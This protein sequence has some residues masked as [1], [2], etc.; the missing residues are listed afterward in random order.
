MNDA[1][2]AGKRPQD[3]AKPTTAD[4][5]APAFEAAAPPVA[6]RRPT[7]RVYHARALDDDYAWLAAENWRDVLRDPAALP[8]DVEA[9]LRAENTYCDKVLAPLK[10]L[11]KSLVAEM[12]GRIK[13]DD[14]EVPTPDGPFVYYERYREGGE[15]PL[16]CRAPRDGGAEEILLDGETLAEGK[17]F[18]DIAAFEHARD[19]AQLAWS[20]DEN[21]GELY[22]IRTRALADGADRADV[23]ADTDGTVVWSADAGSFYYVRIDDN[24]RTAQVFRHD[25][26][27][28][29]ADDSL[30]FEERDPAWFVSLGESQ[31]GRFA[32]V[33]VHGHDATE[34]WLVDLREK[35]PAPRLV[36]PREPRLRYDVEPRGEELF[37]HHN[38][39]GADDFA[40]S[41]APL[42]APARA[43][44]RELIAHR[45]GRMIVDFAVYAHHL[46]RLEREDSLPRIV[47]RELSTGDE[48]QI[49]F[50]EE[51]YA[52]DIEP[53]LE[54]DTTTLRFVYSSMTTPE[55]TYDYDMT[56]RARVLR[57]RQDIPSGHDPAAYTTRRILARA[58]DGE[59]VPVT[60]LH[61]AD[62]A[63]GGAAASNEPAPLLLYAYGAYGYSVSAG[64]DPFA[65]S[66]VDR[67][68]VYAIAHVRGGTEKG[69]RWYEAGKLESKRNTFTD[70][71]ACARHLIG[72]GYTVEGHIVAHGGSAGGLLMGAIANM[73]PEL[74]AGVVATVPFVDALNTMLRDDLPLTPPEWLE[75]G[76]PIA[77][78]AAFERLASYSPYD[79][80]AARAYPPILAIAGLTDPRVTYWE[81]LKW[82]QKLRA[83]MTGGG[84]VLLHTHLGAGHAGASGRFERLDDAALEYAFA[85][86]CA[87]MART[88]KA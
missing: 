11:R 66:L 57:K 77:D 46:V 28:D 58:D 43:N 88:E 74:F 21:G 65:L 31:C 38:A 27:A 19:H 30:V 45:A 32:I 67:G 41:V 49:A 82:A 76:N 47:V 81:P 80:V 3:R 24:H 42:A 20:V 6:E 16:C 7:R 83:K 54:F 84:P 69:W 33:S 15:H 12:R 2:R 25:I 53:G 13:E 68:F 39:D 50:D 22:T 79:N 48:R 37:I 1:D 56:T 70:F 55:E 35:A 71:L 40:I 10:P 23:V 8:K 52:L 60:L 14:A 78:E 4:V 29:P 73:A 59:T 72:A 87:K 34:C 86:A 64:F 51:A 85:L 62:F 75:W 9:L 61:R 26:G 5:P 17:A 18:F 63:A 36:A 44:W